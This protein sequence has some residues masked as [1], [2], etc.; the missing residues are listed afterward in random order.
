MLFL[1][2][3]GV[4]EETFKHGKHAGY[5]NTRAEQ[6]LPEVRVHLLTGVYSV[7]YCLPAELW[8]S[9]SVSPDI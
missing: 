5:G 2:M 7:G 8:P 6:Q 1:W 4:S 9:C 3:R